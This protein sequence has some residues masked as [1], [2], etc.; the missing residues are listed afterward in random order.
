MKLRTQILILLF[1]FGFAPVTA[2]VVTNLPFVLERLE[3]LAQL[4][5]STCYGSVM[6]YLTMRVMPNGISTL[7]K[8]LST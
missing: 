6:T 5:K 1:L 4:W 2:I 8:S 3:F 7:R